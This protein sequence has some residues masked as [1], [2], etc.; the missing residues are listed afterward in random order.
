MNLLRSIVAAAVVASFTLI[1]V[2]PAQAQYAPRVP[3]VV[4]N[5]GSLQGYLNGLGESINV[6][7][8]QVDAQVWQTGVSGN[9]EFTLMVEL[10]GNA[11]QNNIGIYNTGDA[12]P[13]LFQVFPGAAQAGWF[14][15]VTFRNSPS[16][17]IVT[18]FDFDAV[19]QGQTT[20]LN[21]DRTAFGFYLQNPG[22]TFYSQDAR[23]GGAAHVLT[24]AGTGQ[25]DGEWWQCFEDVALQSSDLDYD[26]AVLLL[27]S[28]VPTPTSATSWGRLKGLYR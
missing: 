27:Q 2:A 13:A 4:F 9:T 5:Y 18:L 11:A 10:A 21:V 25:N 23:N 20:Y 22:G 12:V 17:A 3:Q 15:N 26:D 16:R 6:A 19:I 1:A 8:D 14:A 24:Y 7:T 28:V